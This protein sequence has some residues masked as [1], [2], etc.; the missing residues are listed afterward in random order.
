MLVMGPISRGEIFDPGS[1]WIGVCGGRGYL[2]VETII[3]EKH[4]KLFYKLGYFDG[5]DFMTPE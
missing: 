2:K 1:G 5:G 4:I 3:R